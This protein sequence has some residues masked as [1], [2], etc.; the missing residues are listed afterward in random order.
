MPSSQSLLAEHQQNHLGVVF[1]ASE[2]NKVECLQE[3]PRQSCNIIPIPTYLVT[4]RNP[5]KPKEANQGAFGKNMAA[6]GLGSPASLYMPRLG[7]PLRIFAVTGGIG[8]SPEITIYCR[9]M[10]MW[11]LVGYLCV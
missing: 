10:F 2:A 7:L 5:S 4:T 3:Y 11:P 8:G 6:T 9:M 1:F